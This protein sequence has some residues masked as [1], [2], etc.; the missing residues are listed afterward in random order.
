MATKAHQVFEKPDLLTSILINLS[1]RDL[2][3][4]QKVCKTWKQTVSNSIKLQK[5]L[6]FMP[7]SEQ[8]LRINEGKIEVGSGTCTQC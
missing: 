7:E 5:A 2:L 1:T 6:H 3:L 8:R 4:S